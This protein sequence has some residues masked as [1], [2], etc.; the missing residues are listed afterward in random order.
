[1]FDE[2][3]GFLERA[4][5]DEKLDSFPRG[6][7]SAPV[8]GV[9]PLCSAAA[10]GTHAARGVRDWVSLAIFLFADRIAH[11]WE[12]PAVTSRK[13]RA[14]SCSSVHAPAPWTA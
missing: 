5:I 12:R 14:L 10:K 13:T 11:G 2:H 6:E 7:L 1:M 3:S 4:R 9:D 8:L